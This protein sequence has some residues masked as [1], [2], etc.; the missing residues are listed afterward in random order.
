MTIHS[1]GQLLPDEG[2]LCPNCGDVIDRH[3]VPLAA[4]A[5]TLAASS[6]VVAP[7]AP[8]PPAAGRCVE[9]SCP[10]EVLPRQAYCMG[11][12]L[13]QAPS[14]G[15][16]NLSADA[17][18]LLLPDGQRCTLARD[19]PL[20]LG[21]RSPHLQVQAALAPHDTVSRRHAVI[22]LADGELRVTHLSTVNP[23]YANGQ[24]VLPE[25]RLALPVRIGLGESV[26][27]TVLGESTT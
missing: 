17:V 26:T 1:C 6:P 22:E 4:P 8:P 14:A 12:H 11:G 13:A 16:S 10:F 2:L 25:V 18:T 24:P 27:I 7:A 20:E 5:P 9:P 19:V 15:R 21:R 23:T 3:A